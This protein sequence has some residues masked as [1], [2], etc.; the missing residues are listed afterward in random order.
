MEEP[1]STQERARVSR[2]PAPRLELGTNASISLPPA[3]HLPSRRWA[4]TSPQTATGRGRR[5]ERSV[6]S[7]VT[8]SS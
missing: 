4:R 6:S 5:S 7:C 1:V 8:T 2:A 3:Q